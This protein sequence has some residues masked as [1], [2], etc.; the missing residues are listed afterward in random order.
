[1]RATYK[2]PSPF[3]QWQKRDHKKP[4]FSMGF[5]CPAGP[6]FPP[7]TQGLSPSSPLGQWR[8]GDIPMVQQ[9]DWGHSQFSTAF[10]STSFFVFFFLFFL[11][12]KYF[13]LKI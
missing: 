4:S 7:R 2:L 13:I 11:N 9:P 12:L 3:P 8:P 1:M 5:Y 10:S 6:H